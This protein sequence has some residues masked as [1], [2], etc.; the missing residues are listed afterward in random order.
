MGVNSLS[1]CYNALMQWNESTQERFNELRVKK[2]VEGLDEAE[3]AE[4][5]TYQTYLEQETAT[6]LSPLIASLEQENAAMLKKLD[7]TNVENAILLRI[8]EQQKQLVADARHWLTEFEH[9]HKAILQT[10]QSVIGEP[11]VV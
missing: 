3:S 2:F 4:F 8:I 7:E 11:L 6:Y 9:R 1:L 10:Y 5:R